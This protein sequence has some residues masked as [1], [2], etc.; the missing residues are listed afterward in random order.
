MPDIVLL[1]G[2]TT[3]LFQEVFTY[4]GAGLLFN[5]AKTTVIRPAQVGDITHIMMLLRPEI[6]AKR[7][8]PVTEATIERDIAH[9]RVYEVEGDIVGLAR[10]KIYGAWAEMAQFITLHR[11]RGRG[12]ARELAARLEEEARAQGLDAVFALSVEPRM[13]AFFQSLGFREIDRQL[14]PDTWKQNY[15]FNRPSHAFYKAL[16]PE[17]P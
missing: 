10:L 16:K 1:E 13:W 4:D 6:E 7:I 2:K 3:A 14:L 11:Y 17:N 5:R 12:R 8:L 15:D 9:Y